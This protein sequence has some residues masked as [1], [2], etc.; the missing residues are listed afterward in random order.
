M[1]SE[2]HLRRRAVRQRLDGKSVTF[3]CGQL[4]RSR[5]WFYKWWQRYQ[6]QGVDGLRD[7]SCAPHTS[8]GQLSSQIKQVIVAIRDRLVRRWGARDRYRL[9][10]AP[11]IRRELDGLGYACL[12]SLRAIERVL[13]QTDRTS[14]PFRV[15]PTRPVAAYPGPQA[16]HSNHVHQF[17]LVGPRY[18]KGRR[19]RYYFLVYK[20]VFDQAA[21]VEF[22]RAPTLDVVLGF[23]V[24]V[25][26]RL[27][28]P[29]YLQV[30][31]DVLT[32]YADGGKRPRIVRFQNRGRGEARLARRPCQIGSQGGACP[33]PTARS[34]NRPTL[35]R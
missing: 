26:Q 9:A 30:D 4:E 14:P 3:I 16:T 10:G 28:L 29:E 8:S 27:G 5:E 1:S 18:L 7:R 32:S 24:R 17:D 35:G 21:Y 25:W 19:V 2:F 11:A 34:V 22:W 20:D 33:A 13:Q 12:P 23:V 6:E 31:N 15:Q